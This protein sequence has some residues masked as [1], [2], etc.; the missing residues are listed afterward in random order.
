MNCLCFSGSFSCKERR[1]GIAAGTL[2]LG[3]FF[4]EF[5]GLL[6][7]DPSQSFSEYY[8]G[9]HVVDQKAGISH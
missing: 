3:C 7:K 8:G 2:Q 4:M 6:Q 1:T 5:F 9:C